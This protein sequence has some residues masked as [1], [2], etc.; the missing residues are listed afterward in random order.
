L[1]GLKFC[2]ARIFNSVQWCATIC[3]GSQRTAK[4]AIGVG[5]MTAMMQWSANIA[6]MPKTNFA[7][8]ELPGFSLYCRI[9]PNSEN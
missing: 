5:A 8:S 6:S 3:N 9:L 4:I 1:T 7:V 2:V